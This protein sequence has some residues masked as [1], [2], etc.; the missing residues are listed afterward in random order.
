MVLDKPNRHMVA[1][2]LVMGILATLLAVGVNIT[3][4]KNSVTKSDREWCELLVTLDNAYSQTPP[5][6]ETG[7]KVA[8]DIHHLRVSRKC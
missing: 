7:R 4:T 8:R 2:A 6:S 3:Y 5:Q 1:Y